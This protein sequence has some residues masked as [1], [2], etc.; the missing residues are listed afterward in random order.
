MKIFEH[1]TAPHSYRINLFGVRIRFRNIFAFKNNKIIVIDKSGKERRYIPNGLKVKFLGAGSTVKIL[2]PC[3]KFVNTK[4]FCGDNVNILI[5]GSQHRIM[6]SYIHVMSEG[7]SLNI[8]ENNS[9]RGLTIVIKEKKELNVHIGDDCLIASNVKMWTTDFHTVIDAK[10]KQPL[11]S[12]A[13]INIGNHCWLC[14]DVIVAKGASIPDDSIVAARSYVT[15]QFEK[16]NT[17]IGGIPAEIIKDQYTS[18]NSL[19]YDRYESY[20]SKVSA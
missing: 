14:E 1:G 3:P 11:N 16:P 10:T 17:I 19:P 8:G 13:D 15:K 2:S 4:I 7:S 20:L 6:N 12:P 5:G 18:W 9:I